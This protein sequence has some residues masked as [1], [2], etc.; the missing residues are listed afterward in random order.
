[1][2]DFAPSPF[3]GNES[4]ESPGAVPAGEVYEWPL[5]DDEGGPTM[6][7]RTFVAGH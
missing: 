6:D 2:A 3:A 7:V 1:V 5:A 4:F